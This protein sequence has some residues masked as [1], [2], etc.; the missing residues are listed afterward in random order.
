MSE[1]PDY[2]NELYHLM[3]QGKQVFAFDDGENILS[4]DCIEIDGVA[5]RE[6]DQ[7]NYFEQFT[8][9]D[10]L[11]IID[12]DN[13]VDEQWTY[14]LPSLRY[15]GLTAEQY[16]AIDNA[17]CK[18]GIALSLLDDSDWQKHG[19]AFTVVFEWTRHE[20]AKIIGVSTVEL[21]QIERAIK[22][23]MYGSLDEI[24]AV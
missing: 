7:P 3:K 8:L 19:I 10:E 2:K 22:E 14:E 9:L 11:W 12:D 1:L 23:K 5:Y 13:S 20:I 21:A 18:R 17:Y 24:D 4:V 16:E 6:G 15:E